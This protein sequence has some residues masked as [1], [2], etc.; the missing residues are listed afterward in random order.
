MKRYYFKENFGACLQLCVLKNNGTMI[1]SIRCQE[2]KHCVS[3]DCKEGWI[4]CEN[5]KLAIGKQ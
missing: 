4:K 2:C 5:L 3:Y 1:G